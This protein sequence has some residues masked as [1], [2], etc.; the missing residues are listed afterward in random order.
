MEKNKQD[1][2][3]DIN[4][5]NEN[6]L[7]RKTVDKSTFKYGTTIPARYHKVFQ[8]NISD[9]LALVKSINVKLFINQKEFPA[10]V[11]LRKSEV[12]AGITMQLRYSN[13]ALLEL[14]K[15]KLEVSYDYI[16]QYEKENDKK[17]STIPAEYQEYIDF[18]KGDK[19]DTFILELIPKSKSKL[20]D[21]ELEDEVILED[22]LDNEFATINNINAEVTYIYDYI[23]SKGFYY[24]K[25]LIANFYLSLITKPFVILSGISGT[26][27]SKI[28]ELFAEAVGANTNNERFKLIPVRPD[29]SD[30]TDLLGYRNIENK[31]VPGIIID[32]AYEAMQHLDKP[33]FLCLDEMNL[34]RVEY[35]FSDILSSMET[36][37]IND[38]EII[39]QKLLSRAQ[40]GKDERA[41]DKYGDVYIPQ[42]LYI[43]GTVNMDE[44]TFPFSKKVLD[45]ANTIEF[46]TVDLKYNF[47][48]VYLDE[49]SPKK[50]HNDFLKSQYLKISECKDE[51]EIAT[52]VIDKLILINKILEKYQQHFAYRVR[53]EIVFYVIYAVKNQLFSFDQA[54][55]Y[56]IVQKIL[57]KISGSGG[58]VLDILVELFNVLNNTKYKNDGYIEDEQ[59]RAMEKESET[60]KYKLSSQKI[61]YMIRRF[62]RDG[63]TTFWQ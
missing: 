21:E 48:Q 44:T 32:A 5:S 1:S 57:P 13:K 31:F 58:E 22:D 25:D 28:V 51:K 29:W 7:G 12:K 15:E 26:G 6:F 46:N 9:K 53:D 54:M 39:T 3:I 18:Y 40:F 56:S 45:R 47:E 4:G 27:K 37:K 2:W 50:Y 43:I 34:A 11:S 61:M 41:Y 36:R 17:P 35:Y 19:I 14:L 10:L 8:S 20:E 16:V 38:D 55:D 62:L 52:K 23:T 49:L 63:F 60:S 33:Y 30:A 42:N 24:E 59:I